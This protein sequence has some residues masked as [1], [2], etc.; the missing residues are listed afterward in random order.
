VYVAERKTEIGA[1]IFPHHTNVGG[2]ATGL[3][4]AG[5][6][7]QNQGAIAAGRILTLAPAATGDTLATGTPDSTTL[8]T[9]AQAAMNAASPPEKQI[10]SSD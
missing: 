8:R 9:S 7:P 3:D 4:E 6:A 10:G 2:V 5:I 1:W